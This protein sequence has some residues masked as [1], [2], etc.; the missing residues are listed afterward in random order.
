[1]VGSSTS[2]NLDF[3]KDELDTPKTYV[4]SYRTTDNSPPKMPS[5]HLNA[6][7][8]RYILNELKKQ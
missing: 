5:T 6:V 8:L 1:M 3:M 4:H 2:I 7:K